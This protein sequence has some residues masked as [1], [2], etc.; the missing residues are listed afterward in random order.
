MMDKID[1]HTCNRLLSFVYPDESKMTDSEVNAELKRLRINTQ[2][3]M[4]KIL[5]A[6]QKEQ[7]K[8]QAQASLV[9]AKEKRLQMLNVIQ[10]VGTAISNT[11]EGIK[12]WIMEH[13]TGS[14]QALYCR[15]LE[16]S[17]EE[18]LKSL[19][20]DIQCLEELGNHLDNE[21]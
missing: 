17:S 6:L 11:R 10:G 12:E 20:E 1:S 15:K 16:E 13:L 14:Q 5:F 9:S 7:K 18:D 3:A 4:D 2:P 21:E 8:V 19:V